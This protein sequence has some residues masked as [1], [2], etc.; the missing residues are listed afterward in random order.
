VAGDAI[1]ARFE[2]MLADLSAQFINV[3]TTEVD[4]AINAAL[5]RI[6]EILG[7]DRSNLIRFEADQAYVTHS[8]A[9]GGVPTSLAQKIESRFPWASGRLREGHPVIVRALDSLPGDASIDLA[10]WREMGV[11]SHL[12]VPL[13]VGGRVEGALAFGCFRAAHDWPEE[14]VERIGVLADVFAN[15]LDHKRSQLALDTALR[16]EQLVSRILAEML[17]TRRDER[18]AMIQS[19]LGVV[20]QAFGAERAALLE[21]AA[22]AGELTVTHHWLAAGV[23]ERPLW[24]DSSGIAWIRE[25]LLANQT[26][27]FARHAELPAEAAPDLPALRA[28]GIRSAIMVPFAVSGRTIGAI[29]LTT[30]EEREWPGELPPRMRLLGEVFATSLAQRAAEQL[31]QEAQEQAAHAARVGTMGMFAASLIHELT[32][33]LAASLANAENAA[34]L[35]RAPDPDLDELRAAV[36]DI[37]ADDR[38]VRDLIQQLRRFLRRGQSER[39]IV[40]VGELIEDNVA[41]VSGVAAERGIALTHDIAAALPGLTGDRVQLQQVVLNL[42]LNALDAAASSSE[43]PRQVV[44]HARAVDGEVSIE[45]S[46]TGPGID[47]ATIAR[48]FQPFFTTKPNGMGLGLSISRSIV[49]A[50]GGRISVQSEPGRGTTF[51]VQ[52]PSKPSAPAKPAPLGV[53]PGLTGTVFVVDDDPSMR[54]ALQRQLRDAGHTV[55]CFDSA[56][57][58][59]DRMPQ[60]DGACIVSDVRMP[61]QGGLDLQ[62]SLVAAKRDMPIIFISGHGDI[63][64]TVQAFKL[65]AVG[66]VVKP[67]TKSEILNAVG[68]AL[69]R[70][71]DNADQ[72]HRRSVLQ[73][74]YSSLTPREREVFALVASGMLNKLIADRL[75]TAE[76]TIKIHRGRVMEKMEANSIAD[77]VR[78]A[79]ALAPIA[80]HER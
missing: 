61:G 52:L 32:Q 69:A 38:R 34:D 20:A 57:A 41:I 54:R 73:T 79:Q 9:V 21:R 44:A 66:F 11:Q 74:R 3:A 25:R 59:L 56:Q 35:L 13:R 62:A 76:A 7:A 17:T 1:S 80:G 6:A 68:E 33:P 53:T 16:V 8:G 19:G 37:V 27:H 24:P 23:P 39:T 64:T 2:R 60:G 30:R 46:D 67:F 45:V 55:E 36:D 70:G 75:G 14:V 77:L 29:S 51:R 12:S 71:R 15:A 43:A 22:E 40:D 78:M 42:L 28:L 26:V 47:E 31:E 5:R 72:R 63:P 58:F 50:H 10:S 48:M 49:V 4:D 65:G 18:T